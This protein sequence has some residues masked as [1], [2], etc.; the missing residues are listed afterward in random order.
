MTPSLKI[1]LACAAA[2][3]VAYAGYLAYL[4]LYRA[5]HDGRLSQAGKLS[6]VL[7]YTY[8]VGFGLLDIALNVTVF[9]ILFLEPP[10]TLTITNRCQKHMREDSWRGNLARWFC[11]KMLDPFQEGGHC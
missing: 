6:K 5:K 4:T 7:G 8:F 9:T 3:Y 1:V 2:F 10:T 11:E